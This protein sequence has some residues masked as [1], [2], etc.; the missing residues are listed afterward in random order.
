[1][2]TELR[3]WWLGGCGPGTMCQVLGGP[4]EAAHSTRRPQVCCLVPDPPPGLGHV[5]GMCDTGS[6]SPVPS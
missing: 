3:L 5:A 1:M 2:F 6:P 4:S